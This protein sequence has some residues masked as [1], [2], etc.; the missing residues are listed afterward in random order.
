MVAP[1]HPENLGNGQLIL[2]FQKASL[3]RPR[4]CDLDGFEARGTLWGSPG[5][6][7]RGQ[8]IEKH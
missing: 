3:L 6:D 7:L 1:A 4:I 2:P 8:N 5:G